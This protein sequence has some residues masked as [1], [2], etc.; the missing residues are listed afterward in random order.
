[1]AAAPGAVAAS[2]HGEPT[3]DPPSVLVD[4]YTFNDNED[5]TGAPV[6]VCTVEGG[7]FRL[8]DTVR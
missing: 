6:Y 3:S 5:A 2:G 1:V 4:Q 8:V 7:R